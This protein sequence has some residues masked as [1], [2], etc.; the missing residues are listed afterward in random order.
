MKG[1]KEYEELSKIFE[2]TITSKNSPVWV[3][4]QDKFMRASKDSSHFYENGQ[5]ND[6]FYAFM[7]GYQYAKS[8]ARI[9]DLP[10]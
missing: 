6:L 1:T 3:S 4:A 9:G 2:K 8:L 5:I 10:E 7:L